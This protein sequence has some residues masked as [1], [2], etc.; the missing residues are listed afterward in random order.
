MCMN[1]IFTKLFFRQSFRVGIFLSTQLVGIVV[2]EV[3]DHARI[4]NGILSVIH[5][6]GV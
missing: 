5:E 6:K 4:N 1:P 2:L 3:V